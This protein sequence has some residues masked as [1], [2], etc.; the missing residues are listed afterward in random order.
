VVDGAD[1]G[2]LLAKWGDLPT[3]DFGP[4]FRDDEAWQI[5]L[6]MVSTLTLKAEIYDH[7]VTDL[8]AIRDAV[9]AL[10]RRIR[11]LRPSRTTRTRTHSIA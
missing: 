6:E 3:F 1:L 5:G 7:I 11:S 4:T 8:E 10:E 9:P 2:A